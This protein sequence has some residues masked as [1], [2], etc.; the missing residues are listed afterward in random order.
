MATFFKRDAY[1]KLLQWK[2]ESAG[3]TAMLIEGARRVGKSSLA[4]EFGRQ[5]YGSCIL[6]D[7]SRSTEEFKQT[8][9]DTRSNLN[10]FFLYLQAFTG[11]SYIE[12]DTLIVFD[13][14]QS[15]PQAREFIKH[16]VADGR[17]DYMETGSLISLKRNVSD[18]LIPS[19]EEAIVLRPFCFGE[20]LDAFGEGGL[21]ALIAESRRA[22]TPLPT[23]LHRKAELYFRE[24]MLVGGMPQAVAAYVDARDFGKV[25]RAKKAILRL[26]REDIAKYGGEDAHKIRSLFDDIPSQL[27]RKEKRLVLAELDKGART[28]E[29]EDAIKWLS[30]ACLV[31]NCY[32]CTDPDVGLNMTRGDAVKCYLADTGLLA[33]MAYGDDEESSPSLYQEILKGRI[34]SN[35]GMLAE[36]VV[37]QQLVAAGRSLHFYSSYSR[38]AA[39]RMEI[40]FLI[41][42]P[43]PNAA[44]KTRIAPVEVKSGRRYK[45]VSLDKFKSK[46]G[47][48]VGT[49][50]VLHPRAL[51]VKGDRICLPLYMS[52]VV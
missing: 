7:F 31:N 38:V 44:M 11:G 50:F 29:Y 18:I 42:Q 10:Q 19:E 34:E 45:T 23:E 46:F 39:E 3:S 30:D 36:N 26:Y 35:E 21:R 49:E 47:K 5:E 6:V 22:L 2:N 24:Y 13:E 48:K 32:N 9:L 43:Y 4:M 51:E 28:R 8:F 15:F 12:R 52:G 37:A 40:D 41:R 16:L 20:F 33:T 25:E 14:V 1:A 17:Y 27:S